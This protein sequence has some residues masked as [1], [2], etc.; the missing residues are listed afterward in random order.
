MS[1]Y[2]PAFAP[3]MQTLAPYLQDYGYW[4]VFLGVML[5]DFGVPVPGET[6]L[7][8]GSLFAAMGNLKIEWVGVAGLLGAVL[9]DNLG[10]AIGLFGGRALLLHY[11][12]YVLL[13]TKR[14]H[15][16]EDF[17]ARHG[18]KVVTIARFIEGLRQ[19][20]GLLAGASRMYWLRFLYFNIVGAVLWVTTWVS[21]AYFFGNQ[22]NT[23]LKTFKR[24]EIYI[25]V[26]SGVLIVLY[27]GYHLIKVIRNHKNDS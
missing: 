11:G 18:G 9:G 19:F 8:A 13:D 6:L 3:Y 2:P 22:L 16:M 24:F 7:I 26:G 10:Y 12:R 27:A 5:E 21:V 25:L 15:R 1:N 20:N 17:F 14:L 4:A 23:I